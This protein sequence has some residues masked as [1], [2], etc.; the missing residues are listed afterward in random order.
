MRAY[1]CTVSLSEVR[2]RGRTWCIDV[3]GKF[4]PGRAC[5]PCSNPDSPVFSDQGDPPEFDA[6][7]YRWDTDDD[8]PDA[9]GE[10]D[11]KSADVQDLLANG[12]CT[13]YRARR[14][15]QSYAWGH[16]DEPFR[17]VLLETADQSCPY[18]AP[19]KDY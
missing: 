19:E 5:P 12:L 17:D 8:G 2:W 16:Y 11:W 13:V 10:G 7:Y 6:Q 1:K 15:G 14:V 4:D 3:T 9:A 18:Q